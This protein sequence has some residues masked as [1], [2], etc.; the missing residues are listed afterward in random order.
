[1]LSRQEIARSWL[2]AAPVPYWLDQSAH[3]APRPALARPSG[4]ARRWLAEVCSLWAALLARERTR[5]H[6]VI[7]LEADRVGSAA[8]GRN[9][10][11]SGRLITWSAFRPSWASTA[12]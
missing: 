8:T 4:P 2:A 5:G 3:P 9:G 12:R 1:M 11:L 10:G 7:L 6:S